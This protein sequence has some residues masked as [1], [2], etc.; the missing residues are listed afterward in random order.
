MH[1]TTRRF[2]VDETQGRTRRKT[3][4]MQ[5]NHVRGV[6]KVEETERRSALQTHRHV[7]ERSVKARSNHR[8]KQSRRVG[9]EDIRKKLEKKRWDRRNLDKIVGVPW[10]ENADHAEMT[11]Q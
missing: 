1:G 10:L 8:R 5:D 4:K 6:N 3:S 2:F 7:G 11:V 9:Q